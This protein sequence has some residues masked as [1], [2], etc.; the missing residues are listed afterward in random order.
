LRDPSRQ[1]TTAWRGYGDETAIGK[2]IRNNPELPSRSNG[3]AFSVSNT[4]LSIHGYMQAVDGIGTRAI[5]SIIRIEFKS[6]GKLPDAWQLDTLFK[7]HCGINTRP[8]GYVVKGST[9]VNHGIYLCVCS[10]MTPEDSDWI[11]W[12]RFNSQGV[13][14]WRDA[15]LQTLN[16]LLRFDT[17][18]KTFEHCWLRRHHK[19]TVVHRVQRTPLGFDV[20][21][22]IT[23]RS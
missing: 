4:D 1:N 5:Q 6:H 19:K 20:E 23:V 16:A 17:H 2:W 12:G 8:R 14:E 18:P 3:S 21:Q 10:G 11:R 9:I 15:S 13:P 7:E 22:E